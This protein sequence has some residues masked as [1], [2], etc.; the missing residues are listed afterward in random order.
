[1]MTSRPLASS[2]AMVFYTMAVY[3]HTF[4]A[5]ESNR[6]RGRGRLFLELVYITVTLV[7]FKKA[8]TTIHCER[9]FKSRKWSQTLWGVFKVVESPRVL[10]LSNKLE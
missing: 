4:L 5:F 8:T 1:M 7:A 6:V 2:S 10:L 3:G 9:V